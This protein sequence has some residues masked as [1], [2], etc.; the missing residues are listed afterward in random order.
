MVPATCFAGRAVAVFGLARSGL[1]AVASLGAGGAEVL[2]WDDNADRR[3]AAQARGV[4]L[5]DLHEADWSTLA[6]LV[7]SPGVPLTHPEPHWTVQLARNAGVEVIGDTEIFERERAAR[8]PASKL[9]AI[10]GTNGKSTT[11]ALIAHVLGEAGLTVAMGGNIGVPILALDDVADGTVYVIEYSSYQIDLTP[12]LAPSVGILLNLSEDHLDRHGDMAHYAEVKARLVEAAAKRGMAVVGVGDAGSAAIANTIEKTGGRILRIAAGE[13]LERGIFARDARLY[14]ALGDTMQEIADLSG[15][16][17]LRGQHNWQN[18][19]AAFA[20][21]RVLGVLPDRIS[22]GL[23]S[24]PGLAHRMEQVRRIGRALFVND[25][26]ATNADAA[27]RALASF[28]TIY[29][30]AGGQPKSG[31]IASLERFF[32][33]IEHAYLIGEAAENFAKTLSGKVSFTISGDLGTAVAMAARAAGEARAG[34]P[35]VLLSPA[36]ASF[37]QF[38]NFEA[39][40]DAFRAAVEQLPGE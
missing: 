15:T 35:V 30:I 39:R 9:V 28:D 23:R 1:A 3:A 5:C 38:A 37:D 32:A 7:L 19:A 29:W 26:K 2:A 36:C 14:Q 22:A 12:G 6:A 33:K 25:S 24:F 13:R 34:E 18:A 31:G 16:G 4:A 10:T 40:G 27:A 17:S 21:C 20:A 8:A 11:T